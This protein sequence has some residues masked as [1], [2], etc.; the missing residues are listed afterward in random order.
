MIV[1]KHAPGNNDG[2]PRVTVLHM[3]AA[4]G[5][6]LVAQHLIDLW[7]QN[8]DALFPPGWVDWNSYSPMHYLA[9][10]ADYSS[11][12]T[13]AKLYQDVGIDVDFPLEDLAPI[14]LVLACRL[15]SFTAARALL[16]VGADPHATDRYGT[17]C[18]AFAMMAKYEAW[19]SR[20]QSKTAW[21]LGRLCFIRELVRANA[22]STFPLS[23]AAQWGRVSEIKLL[24]DAGVCYVD[25]IDDEDMTPLAHA[26]NNGHVEIAQI[27]LAAGASVSHFQGS[28]T[29]AALCANKEPVTGKHAEILRLLLEQGATIGFCHNSKPPNMTTRSYSGSVLDDAMWRVENT[30]RLRGATGIEASTFNFILKHST[31]TNF[32][33]TC[34]EEAMSVAF[35][36]FD[37]DLSR[38]GGYLIKM[39]AE[40]GNRYGFVL[41]DSMLC[42]LLETLI[43]RGNLHDLDLFFAL[44][45][46]IG[47]LGDAGYVT[48]KAA[49]V[50]A[51]AN[52][53]LEKLKW[54][55]PIGVIRYLLEEL[56]IT[57]GKVRMLGNATLLHLACFMGEPSI[58][59]MI[60][61]SGHYDLQELWW[62]ATPLMLAIKV[63]E[64]TCRLEI[65]GLLLS[66]GANPFLAPGDVIDVDDVR[67]A[68]TDEV[69]DILD[70]GNLP[71]SRNIREFLNRLAER[72]KISISLKLLPYSDDFIDDQNKRGQT[73]LPA[74]VDLS[75][76]ELVK[77]PC[78][79]AFTF[80]ILMQIVRL[81]SK[82]NT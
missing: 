24:L 55:K 14:P 36:A 27:L 71:L 40:Y 79:T 19:A 12:V 42:I 50:L 30:I 15:G 53:S 75:P 52:F 49:L 69:P 7:R 56:P 81:S 63:E 16:E 17:A 44:G 26:A 39:L 78:P 34:W 22:L 76:F 38:R 54:D 21:E 80:L 18:M 70:L 20:R 58:V 35:E 11:V 72:Q 62:S 45:D 4:H 59:H 51:M 68:C 57:K 3:A 73:A 60:L 43:V 67:P 66:R 65:I 6:V 74:R 25:Q 41:N 64:L 9:L 10:C 13:I 29:A 82:D 2:A 37:L 32:P 47:V 5:Q 77:I 31:P 8:P 23:D 46:S 33:Q 61:D 48:R 28:V 1:S